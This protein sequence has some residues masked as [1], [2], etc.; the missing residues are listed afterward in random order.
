MTH[1]LSTSTS[2]G[3]TA[4]GTDGVSLRE[5]ERVV[6]C[7]TTIRTRSSVRTSAARRD[8]PRAAAARRIGHRGAA[9]GSRFP[10][11]HRHQGV[12]EVTLPESQASVPE[13]LLE[14][15]Y[16]GESSGT[17]AAGSTALQDDPYRHLPMLGEFDLHLIAEGRHEQLWTV[18]GATARHRHRVRGVGAERA[19][20]PGD[21]RLQL[22]GRPRPPDALAWRR[23]GVGASTSLAWAHGTRY[24]YS[25]CGPDGEWREKP[26]R[27]RCSPRPRRPPP[28]WCT[29]R[30]TSGPTRTG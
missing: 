13:Y 10:M 19:R 22:L 17:Y 5:I 18:L 4:P 9:R 15:T 7:S 29:S 16:P 6:A 21:R 3:K 27:W 26:T 24:K 14:V 1:D 23:G 2:A 12:F 11:P 20:R 25:I 28:P 30:R 8:D